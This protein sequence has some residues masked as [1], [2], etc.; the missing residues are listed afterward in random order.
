MHHRRV[1][2]PHHPAG[3]EM[4]QEDQAYTELVTPFETLINALGVRDCPFHLAEI[5]YIF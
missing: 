1:Q 2:V 4:R 3:R 5:S